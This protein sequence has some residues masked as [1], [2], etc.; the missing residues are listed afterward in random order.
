[1]RALAKVLRV[2]LRSLAWNLLS[3]QNSRL[4]YWEMVWIALALE[5]WWLSAG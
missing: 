2:R 3:S 5:R 1:M 4:V